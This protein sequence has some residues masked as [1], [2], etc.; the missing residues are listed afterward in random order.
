MK[1]ERNLRRWTMKESLIIN[2]LMHEND[3]LTD[4]IY[5]AKELI[6]NRSFDAIR[7]RVYSN[8]LSLGKKPMADNNMN[9]MEQSMPVMVKQPKR[10]KKMPK[11]K[12]NTT[13]GKSFRVEIKDDHVRLYF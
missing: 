5:A 1:K 6:P 4:V 9:S 3:N 12:T 11:V 13:N 8:R 10:Q 7:M 2:Q